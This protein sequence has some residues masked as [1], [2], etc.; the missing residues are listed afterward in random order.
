[1][2]EKERRPYPIQQSSVSS[3][4]RHA[5]GHGSWAQCQ[6]F[7][8]SRTYISPLNPISRQLYSHGITSTRL[9]PMNATS[10]PDNFTPPLALPAKVLA[11][12]PPD[13]PSPSM[14]VSR[15][16][17]IMSRS[18]N[19]PQNNDELIN[20]GSHSATSPKATTYGRIAREAGSDGRSDVAAGASGLLARTGEPCRADNQTPAISAAV[21]KDHSV[22][23]GHSD[24]GE[25]DVKLDIQSPL[26]QVSPKVGV[27]YALR[28]SPVV[29]HSLALVQITRKS[30][31]RT[32]YP[33]LNHP[34]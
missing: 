33:P 21:S 27:L 4:P 23:P 32:I 22:I 7:H 1:L 6:E 2:E 25:L 12:S 9:P 16:G 34:G 5:V 11:Y 26:G 19:I 8:Q 18:T 28:F 30:F 10:R 20:L 17:D 3:T 24:I 15:S 31:L 14:P 13:N 29:H